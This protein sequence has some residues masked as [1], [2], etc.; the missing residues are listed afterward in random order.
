MERVSKNEKDLPEYW[1]TKS[2]VLVGMESQESEEMAHQP[3]DPP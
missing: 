3:T 2:G 1:I